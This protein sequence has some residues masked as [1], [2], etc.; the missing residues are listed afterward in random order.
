MGDGLAWNEYGRESDGLER[1]EEGCTAIGQK[2]GLGNGGM[3]DGER[4][5]VSQALIVRAWR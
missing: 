2:N 5:S 3:E 1:G 4:N